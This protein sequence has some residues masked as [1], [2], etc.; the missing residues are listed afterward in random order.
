MSRDDANTPKTI[1]SKNFSFPT[2]IAMSEFQSYSRSIWLSSSVPHHVSTRILNS[3]VFPGRRSIPRSHMTAWIDKPSKAVSYHIIAILSLILGKKT[4]FSYLLLAPSSASNH[5]SV[6]RLLSVLFCQQW[7]LIA[8]NFK[9]QFHQLTWC[10]ID[11][12][13]IFNI[14]PVYWLVFDTVRI[15]SLY[16]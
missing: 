14:V 1:W 6:M 5:L 4:A 16:G 2:S 8:T 12:N 7:G 15:L 13:R 9:S 11:F 3:L 10:F